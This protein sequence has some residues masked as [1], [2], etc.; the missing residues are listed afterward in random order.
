MKSSLGFLNFSATTTT[1]N[2]KAF[3]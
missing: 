1:F 3:R 2:E